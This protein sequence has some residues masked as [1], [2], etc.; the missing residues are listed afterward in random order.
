MRPRARVLRGVG[1]MLMLICHRAWADFYEAPVAV[2]YPDA[3][4]AYAFFF[5]SGGPLER[6]TGAAHSRYALCRVWLIRGAN[7][8][9]RVQHDVDPSRIRMYALDAHPFERV[10]TS[11]ELHPARLQGWFW[12]SAVYEVFVRLSDSAAEPGS[13]VLIE[14]RPTTVDE[15]PPRVT[16]Q[17]ISMGEREALMGRGRSRWWFGRDSVVPPSPLQTQRPIELPSPEWGTPWERP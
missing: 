11:I 1:A 14:W 15:Q 9:I 8:V 17:L 12:H 10:R 3:P 4:P 7:H 16:V 6:F 13:Y 5:N 2:I